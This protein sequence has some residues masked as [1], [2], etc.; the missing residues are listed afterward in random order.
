MITMRAQMVWRPVG[1]TVLLT[2]G[3]MWCR[4][5]TRR[6]NSMTLKPPERPYHVQAIY[7]LKENYSAEHFRYAIG[8]CRNVIA[9]VSAEDDRSDQQKARVGILRHLDRQ[10]RR[11]VVWV[12]EE[13]DLTAIALRNLIELRFWTEY[14]SAGPEQTEKFLNEVNID[15][16][17]LHAKME[18]AF[19][20]SLEPLPPL[21]KGRR[22]DLTRVDDNEEYNFKLCSKLIHATAL[23]INHPEATVENFN[24][25]EYMA[26][27]VL[28]YAWWIVSR[29]HELNWVD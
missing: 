1:F 18:K 10:L 14:I 26:V 12:D 23:T 25:R 13:A 21:P 11:A 8:E 20:G 17:D 6:Y 15:I 3:I 16:Q 9:R 4:R 27:E 5:R 24:Y 2:A 28:F 7:D 29:F 22:I 19:P